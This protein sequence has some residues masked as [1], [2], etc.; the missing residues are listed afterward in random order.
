MDPLTV[1]IFNVAACSPLQTALFIIGGI[2]H[3]IGISY[4]VIIGMS[5]EKHKDIG[6]ALMMLGA[7]IAAYPTLSMVGVA[8][9][10]SSKAFM[11][12][13]LDI[14]PIVSIM[15]IFTSVMA[16]RSA[17]KTKNDEP[18]DTASVPC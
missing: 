14:K 3:I 1:G 2:L 16:L 17:L 18:L 15:L 5:G 4:G 9:T 12:G 13:G 8:L 11:L 7:G 6:V 10:G